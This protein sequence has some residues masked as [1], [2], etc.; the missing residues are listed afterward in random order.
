MIFVCKYRKKILEPISD[1]L[2]QVIFDISKN[3][4]FEII[5]MET[6]KNHVHLL[7]KSEPKYSTLAIVRRLKQE[8]TIRLWKTQKEYLSKHY[9]A[10]HTLWSDGYF[11]CSIGNISKETAA[12]YIRNQG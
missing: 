9:W 2:K 10:E 1:E 4:N 7:I 3:S 6:D 12:E 8:T 11:V 5:E